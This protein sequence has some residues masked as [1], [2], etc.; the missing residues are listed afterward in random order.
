MGVDHLKFS[1]RPMLAC[2]KFHPSSRPWKAWIW[3][4]VCANFN[5]DAIGGFAT[6]SIGIADF[7][8][9]NDKSLPRSCSS[10]MDETGEG[11]CGYLKKRV[12]SCWF[13]FS[14]IQLWKGYQLKECG[15]VMRIGSW[16]TLEIE[17]LTAPRNFQLQLGS[18]QPNA[19]G[20]RLGWGF[21]GV[22]H[23]SPLGLFR[24]H[25]VSR[26]WMGFVLG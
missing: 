8:L 2:F 1:S 19:W 3:K 5:E 11:S 6:L 26:F 20:A 17:V 4:T 22:G 9:V 10:S 7:R 14:K 13:P 15:L 18:A 25:L 21:A 12:V 16:G 23:I 24:P